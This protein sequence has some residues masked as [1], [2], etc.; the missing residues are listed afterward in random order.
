M[1]VSD[2][3]VDTIQLSLFPFLHSDSILFLIPFVIM[4]SC[5][6]LAFVSNLIHR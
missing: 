5:G 2:F 4:A 1:T 3:L 6:F